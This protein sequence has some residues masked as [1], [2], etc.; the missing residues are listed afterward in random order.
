M[1]LWVLAL[2]VGGRDGEELGQLPKDVAGE[3]HQVRLQ[4]PH[5]PGEQVARA[6]ADL[7]QGGMI[8]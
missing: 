2:C 3:G 8:S 5:Q 4:A 1:S 6:A 7:G